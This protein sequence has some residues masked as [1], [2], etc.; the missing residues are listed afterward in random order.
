MQECQ[1]R[2]LKAK[3]TSSV[4]FQATMMEERPANLITMQ[5][6]HCQNPLMQET[7]HYKEKNCMKEAA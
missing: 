3:H 5:Q 2:V 4:N 6:A 7:T 1:L